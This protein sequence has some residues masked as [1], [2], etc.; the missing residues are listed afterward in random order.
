MT[1]RDELWDVAIDQYGFVT[2]ANAR[3]L[4]IP[5]VELG[6]LASRG[7]LVRASHGVYRFPQWPVSDRD[8]L[9]EAVLWTKDS[10][11]VLS[12]DTALD[13]LDLC[14]IN[15][16]KLHLTIPKRRWGLQRQ[17][18]PATYVIHQ[19]NLEPS[20]RGWWEQIP[21]VTAAAAIRQGITAKVRPDLLRQAID[22]AA[23]RGLIGQAETG[24]LSEQVRKAFSK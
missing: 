20:E 23:G 17:S 9:M 19:Q 24:E 18:V 1:V 15:P 16:T 7:K 11:A 4:G 8:H 2:A 6:K 21:C 5:V 13:V 22:A 12:H 10:S 3:D 14:D